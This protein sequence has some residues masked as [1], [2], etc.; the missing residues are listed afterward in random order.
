MLRNSSTCDRL[1]GGIYIL[2]HSLKPLPAW[3]ITASSFSSCILAD[4]FC[5]DR[6]SRWRSAR[7]PH[8][9]CSEPWTSIHHRSSLHS[10]FEWTWIPLFRIPETLVSKSSTFL[11]TKFERIVQ[12]LKS[13]QSWIET[14]SLSGTAIWKAW[15]LMGSI[16]C[17]ALSENDFLQIW[18]KSLAQS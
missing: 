13:V 11:S 15:R 17:A 5:S 4:F 2:I 6:D 8:H 3:S 9:L 18:R 7:F 14:S 16:V 10:P 12:I 1:H